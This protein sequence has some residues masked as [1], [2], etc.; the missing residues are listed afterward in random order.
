MGQALA[1]KDRRAIL[2]SAFHCSEEEA[3]GL[4][5]I[6][7]PQVY[8]DRHVIVHQEDETAHVW[9]VVEG[10]AHA[11]ALSIEGQYTRITSYEPGE[12]FGAY[13]EPAPSRSEIAAAGQ[14]LV[15][16]ADCAAL[17]E[18]AGNACA[19]ALGLSH[20]LAVQLDAVLDRLAARV[21]ITATGRVYAELDKLAGDDH[22]VAPPPVIAAL[23]IRAQTTRETASRAISALER[24]G[25]IR[26]DEHRLE[27]LAP[28]ALRDLIA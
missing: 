19:V 23:A 5:S 8:A 12:L 4:D 25:I 1:S 27:I 9:L 22:T 28:R 21:T 16:R 14:L 11:Q 6:F 18:A 24:R 7:A 17:N 13:P 2:A 26:R 20:L 15:L 3:S 10:S